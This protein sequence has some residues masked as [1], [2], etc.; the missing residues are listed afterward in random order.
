MGDGKLRLFYIVTKFALLM[1]GLMAITGH[2]HATGITNDADHSIAINDAILT[3]D[4]DVINAGVLQTDSGSIKLDGNWANTGTFN[5]GTSGTIEFIGATASTI[6]GTN[7]F[8]NF[9]SK[10]DG[11]QLNFEAGKTQ[12][13]EGLWTITGSSGSPILLRSTISGTQW[14]VDLKG[15]EILSFVDVKDSNNLS[16]I[17]IDPSSSTN[18]GNNT[19]WFNVTLSPTVTPIVTPIGTPV[20]IPGFIEGRITD[21]ITTNGISN[22]T[23]LLT[24]TQRLETTTDDNGEYAFFSIEPGGYKLTVSIDGFESKN[25][26]DFFVSSD[27]V[28][29]K[30]ICLN[31]IPTT[32]TSTATITPTPT[33]TVTPTP[34]P[35]PDEKPTAEFKADPRRGFTPL[36]VNFTDESTGNPTSW[37]MGL[38]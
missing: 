7:T 32:A 27:D 29:I 18:S 21:C 24:G 38:W 12:T 25:S 2:L 34:T 6:S 28:V 22:V 9:T 15:T 35:R 19:N 26:D 4:G 5:A 16:P 3:V 36:T 10:E 37:G 30:D 33:P 20:P 14:S 8:A 11:K 17:L 1:I 13:I 31:E 23:V